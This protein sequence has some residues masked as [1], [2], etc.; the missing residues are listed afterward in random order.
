MAK[1]TKKKKKLVPN[2]GFGHQSLGTDLAQVEALI[3]REQWL[4]A[5]SLLRRLK[6]SHPE[7]LDVLA[8]QIEVFYELG[9][10]HQYQATCE[11]F[12]ALKPNDARVNFL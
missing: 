11:K 7:N 2:R 10:L 3:R 9:H 12:L 1:K 5:H 8:H 6:Q 4:E